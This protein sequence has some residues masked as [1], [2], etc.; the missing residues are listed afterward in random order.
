M[1]NSVVKSTALLVV[2]AVA[3]AVLVKT[4]PAVGNA[5]TSA[6]NWFTGL[7]KKAKEEVAEEAL[8]VADK[9]SE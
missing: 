9:L 1:K 2:G 6:T 8:E 5:V 3:G 7:F 4:V